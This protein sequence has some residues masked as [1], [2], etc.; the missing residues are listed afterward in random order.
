MDQVRA[1]IDGYDCGVLF[2]DEHAGQLFEKLASLDVFDE[3]A[4]MI[5]ADHGET[6]GELNI[7]GDHQTADEQTSRV[8]MIL[9]WPALGAEAAG[10]VDGAL[11]YQF[12]VAASVLDLL[13]G[14]VPRSWDGRSFA[15]ALREGREDGRNS[16]VLSQAAWTCQRAVRMADWLG[17]RTYH[18]GYHPFP[19]WMLFDVCEDPHETND[20]ATSKPEVIERANR[21]LEA[22]YA[23]MAQPNDPMDTVMAEGGPFH[24]RG[25]LGR[26]LE[27]LRATERAHWAE[28]LEQRH[29][30]EL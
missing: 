4:L 11:H 14:R 22:W 10:R 12:D 15:P 25:Q 17:I 19:E 7:Y 8:P 16:L 26:Y 23:E 28:A 20:L 24:T 18:D 1:V 29:P 2:A 30:E 27:R 21:E 13:G 6:L 9:R 3:T 5:S